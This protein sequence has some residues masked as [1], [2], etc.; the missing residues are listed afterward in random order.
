MAQNYFHGEN[1]LQINALLST[2]AWGLNKMM[3]ILKDHIKNHLAA[4]FKSSFL[5]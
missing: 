1:G 4:F 3:K 5:E 2:T